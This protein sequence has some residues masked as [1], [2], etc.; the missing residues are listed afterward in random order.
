MTREIKF[1][2]WNSAGVGMKMLGDEEAKRI[3]YNNTSNTELFHNKAAVI[4]QF[5]GLK[6][7]KGNEIYEGDVYKANGQN[8]AVYFNNGA[9]A[10][11]KS[12]DSCSPLGWDADGEYED[13]IESGFYNNIEIIGNIY[14]NPELLRNEN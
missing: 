9:F 10:G 3:L 1:R 5:T 6:D 7:S 4:M 13:M 8:Y 14:E 12:I 2:A 11:G